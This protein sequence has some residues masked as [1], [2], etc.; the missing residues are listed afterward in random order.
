V[1]T[2]SQAPQLLLA[3]QDNH[4]EKTSEGRDQHSIARLSTSQAHAPHLTSQQPTIPQPTPFKPRT[5]AALTPPAPATDPLHPKIQLHR[6]INIIAVIHIPIAI[7]NVVEHVVRIKIAA[8]SSTA[9]AVAVAWD[10]V[11]AVTVAGTQTATAEHAVW[12]MSGGADLCHA[13]WFSGVVVQSMD[14]QSNSGSRDS[15]QSATPISFCTSMV[16]SSA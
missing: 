3:Q 11:R 12:D 4:R 6:I 8:A 5:P 2:A 16:C 14:V 7:E 15:A 9:V 13:L 1:C 10:V